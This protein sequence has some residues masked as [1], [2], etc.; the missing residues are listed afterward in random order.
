MAGEGMLALALVLAIGRWVLR[1]LFYEIAH[2]RL[3]ELFTLTVLLVVLS[4]AWITQQLGLSMALGAFLAGMMLAES[5]YR[6]QV[7]SSVRPFKELL[8]G[9]FFISVGMLLDLRLL[10]HNFFVVT[11]LLAALLLGKALLV[12]L[13]ARGFVSSHFKAVRTSI[14][15]VGGGEFG[16]ALLT[17]LVRREELVPER[18]TQPLLAAIVLSMMLSPLII[19]ANRRIARL[20]LGEKGPPGSALEREVAV[21][22]ALARREHVVLCGFGR[23]GQNIARVLESQGFEYIAIDLDPARIRLARNAGDT[24]LFGD[25][26]DE[27]LLQ[28]AGLD[29]ASAV[30]ITF[31]NPAV[32]VGIVRAVRRLRAD[33]PVLVRTQDDVGLAD[34]NAAGATEVVPETFE[35]SLMLVSQVLML[36]DVPVGK[37]V[38]TVGDIRAER[39]ATLRG[40]FRHDG[41]RVVDD[42]H[43]FR[44]ELRSV[45][46]PPQAWSIGRRIDDV[47]AQGADVSFTA[48]RR[49][50]ITGRQPDGDTELREGDIVVIYGTPEA[51]EHAEAVLLAG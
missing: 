1:P 12:T 5:E 38:R 44:E 3:R 22:E 15:L 37:V 29:A 48:V 16:V 31:A 41:A 43:A 11:A 45:V 25:S 24:V 9:L 23:V 17:I 51:L 14:V 6:H 49:Q 7:E 47:R 32:S 18:F 27:E 50:G 20:L 35:A 13:V 28:H 36:L 10:Y 34:L 4:A 39:Y 46:L 2:S 30:I 26:A 8:L 19:R 33:V 42:T 21:T 40:I